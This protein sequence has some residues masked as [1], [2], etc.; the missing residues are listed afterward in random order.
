MGQFS[1]EIYALPGSVLDGNQ[2]IKEAYTE[3]GV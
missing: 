2:Q 3:K 1:V